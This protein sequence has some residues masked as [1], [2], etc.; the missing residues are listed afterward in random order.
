MKAAF[1]IGFLD[2]IPW[3][4]H[5]R[6]ATMASTERGEFPHRSKDQRAPDDDLWRAGSQL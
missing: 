4:L 1:A 6:I 3:P 5:L 2:F